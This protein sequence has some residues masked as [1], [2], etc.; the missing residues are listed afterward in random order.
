MEAASTLADLAVGLTTRGMARDTMAIL[1]E[2][3]AKLLREWSAPTSNAPIVPP[4][5]T[6]ETGQ[7]GDLERWKVGHRVYGLANRSASSHLLLATQSIEAETY[8][9]AVEHLTSASHA[10]RFMTAAM[11]FAASTSAHMYAT[12]VR[13]TMHPP[14]LPL[15]LTGAMNLD[16]AAYRGA[17]DEFLVACPLTAAEATERSAVL[18]DG[19]RQLLN[20][21]LADLE[22]HITIAFRLVGTSPALDEREHESA[23]M[24]LRALYRGRM[25]RF[26]PLLSS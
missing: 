25:D 1:A 9:A 24:S 17:L 5:P 12:V 21:D 8:P 18:A 26:S 22:Q 4:T 3:T 11:E 13:P 6:S 23:V 19:R 14:V 16:H 15:E 7:L 2:G 10:V 20:A